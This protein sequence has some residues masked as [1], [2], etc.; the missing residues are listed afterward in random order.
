MRTNFQIDKILKTIEAYENL[1]EET[2]QKL[3]L[4]RE[5]NIVYH[6]ESG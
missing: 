1:D 5:K 6:K 2:K 3:L 4:E